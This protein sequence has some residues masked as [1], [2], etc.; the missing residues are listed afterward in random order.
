MSTATETKAPRY[1]TQLQRFYAMEKPSEPCWIWPFKIDARGYGKVKYQGRARKAHQVV[2]E[3]YVGPVPDGLELDHL[4][5]ITDCVNPSH[6]EP[7][8]HMENIRRRT[9]AKTHCHKGHE[10]T[11]E[12]TYTGGGKR[13][14]RT[15]QRMAVA[16]YTERRRGGKTEETQP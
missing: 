12:N 5:R 7:V 11:A 1:P 13:Q 2:Y 9:A 3:H 4:C 15:C 6:L 14:C 10:Y 8:T 16:R